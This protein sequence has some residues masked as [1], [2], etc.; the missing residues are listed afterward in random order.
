MYN[1]DDKQNS[2]HGNDFY[3]KQININYWITRSILNCVTINLKYV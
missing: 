2:K 1:S 3:T